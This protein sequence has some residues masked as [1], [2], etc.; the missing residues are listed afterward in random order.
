M[1]GCG[2]SKSFSSRIGSG[3]RELSCEQSPI[4]NREEHAEISYLFVGY[5]VADLND[6]RGDTILEHFDGLRSLCEISVPT[7]I[8]MKRGAK[9]YRN[10]AREELYEVSSVKD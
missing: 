6:I 10:T 4:L 7:K 8:S 1:K 2:V 3:S 9:A 5:L